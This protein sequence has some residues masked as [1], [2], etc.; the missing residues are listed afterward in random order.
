MEVVSNNFCKTGSVKRSEWDDVKINGKTC[1]ER[2]NV[3]YELRD[4]A[5]IGKRIT[6]I[7]EE[8]KKLEEEKNANGTSDNRKAEIDEEIE[9]LKEEKTDLESKKSSLERNN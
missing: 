9:E 7:D 4:P 1:K 2:L 6:E 5:E 8:I 3:D